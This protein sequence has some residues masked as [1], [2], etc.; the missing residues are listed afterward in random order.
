MTLAPLRRALLATALV[1]AFALTSSV[2]D[3]HPRKDGFMDIL[4]QLDLDM[5][6]RQDLRQ[7]L[8]QRKHDS[9]PL[10][11]DLRSLQR[12]IHSVLQQESLD[13][14]QLLALLKERQA[15]GSIQALRRAEKHHEL[16]SIL[17]DAQRDKF[18][19]LCDARMMREPPGLLSRLDRLD[20]SPDQQDTLAQ[21][22]SQVI[23][24]RAAILSNIRAAKRREHA[25]I[26]T[27]TFSQQQWQAVY[28]EHAQD[29][30]DLALLTARTKHQ[31]WHILNAS[32]QQIRKHRQNRRD[33]FHPRPFMI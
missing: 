16:W 19:A 4:K 2:A 10:R 32:Q 21:L 15:L 7:M 28:D 30:L 3:A 5:I 17:N 13:N 1:A 24:K 25:L 11:T 12:Q 8:R 18:V 20:L 31:V 9:K 33:Q 26:R 22:E 14:E 6:Q 23:T 27:V 29:L